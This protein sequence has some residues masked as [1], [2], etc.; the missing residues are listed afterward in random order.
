MSHPTPGKCPQ[1][2]TD[3]ST[4]TRLTTRNVDENQRV[5]ERKT[6]VIEEDIKHVAA[7]ESSD[8]DPVHQI[9]QEN[10]GEPQT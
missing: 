7:Q 1:R 5:L 10:G 4:K 6:W 2:S 3:E 8:Y 9:H